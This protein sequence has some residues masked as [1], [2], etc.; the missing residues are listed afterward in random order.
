MVSFKTKAFDFLVKPVYK[1]ALELSIKRLW[2]DYVQSKK[3]KTLSVKSGSN[4]YVLDI[5]N[6]LYLEKFG[7][8]MIVHT[9]NSTI[10][11]Y[12]S[13]ETMQ[14]K[15]EDSGFFR[16]HKSYLIN[17]RHIKNISIADSKIKMSNGEYC[18]ISRNCKKELLEH[19]T[20]PI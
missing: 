12:E 2:E 14:R 11:T 5:N 6:I 8:I 15:L 20:S 19:V 1:D 9:K 17:L 16:C 3:S 7:Q 4:I 18:L 10:R 13:L